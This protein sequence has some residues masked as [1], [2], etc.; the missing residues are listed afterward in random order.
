MLLLQILQLLA[1]TTHPHARLHFGAFYSSELGGIVTDPGFMVVS[2]DDHMVHRGDAVCETVELVEGYL[3]Q[4]DARMARFLQ[5][6]ELAG[7]PLPLSEARLRRILLDTAAASCKLNGERSAGLPATLSE[8]L[9]DGQVGQPGGGPASQSHSSS[10]L[11]WCGLTSRPP[12]FSV[13]YEA[14]TCSRVVLCAVLCP[15]SWS[16]RARLTAHTFK[17]A[18]SSTRR[19]T[20]RLTGVC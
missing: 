18:S 16:S 1:E 4:F 19:Q 5:S 14:A 8:Q 12:T 15:S 13:R 3:Y 6:A 20:V 9:S 17:A 2:I 10:R 11:V 7:L